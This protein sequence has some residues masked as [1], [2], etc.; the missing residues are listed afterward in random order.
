MTTLVLPVT[1]K[2]I[3]LKAQ[4][5]AVRRAYF[6]YINERLSSNLDQLDHEVYVLDVLLQV[7][8]LETSNTPGS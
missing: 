1:D 4:A 7:Q 2:Y 6:T 5:K 8:E 3:A